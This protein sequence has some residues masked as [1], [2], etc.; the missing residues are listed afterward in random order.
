MIWRSVSLAVW[1]LLAA[2][3]V[4]FQVVTMASRGRLVGLGEIVKGTRAGRMIALLGWMWLG[5]HLFAR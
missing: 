3:V 1:G 4:G 5:W 2:L